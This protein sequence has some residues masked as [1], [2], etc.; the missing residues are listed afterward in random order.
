MGG[1]PRAATATRRKSEAHGP[2]ASPLGLS[3]TDRFVPDLAGETRTIAKGADVRIRGKEPEFALLVL[4]GLLFR[5]TQMRN[6]ERQVVALYFPGD[7]AIVE[8]FLGMPLEGEIAALV[9]SDVRLVPR[10]EIRQLLDD[11]PRIFRLLTIETLFQTG[12]QSQWLTR[13][14]VMPAIASLAHFLCEVI[15][16]SGAASSGPVCCPFPFSQRM[17]GETLGLT[18]V[19]VNRTF[20]VLREQG[21]AEV[22]RGTLRVS[23]QRELEA[24]AKFDPHYLELRSTPPW[25]WNPNFLTVVMERPFER[26]LHG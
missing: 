14:S 24:L 20:R 4:S 16:R 8:A 9:R 6:G 17:V 7:W 18:Y 2:V 15:I 12:V 10:R 1:H 11:N 21:L 5:Y 13:N 23:S 19:H 26:S 22:D 25:A 3:G